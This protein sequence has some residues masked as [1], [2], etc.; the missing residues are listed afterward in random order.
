MTATET[1]A[2]W[3]TAGL[4]LAILLVGAVLGTILAA[5]VLAIAGAV[6]RIP[7]VLP[8][9][10]RFLTADVDAPLMWVLL[11]SSWMLGIVVT[12][13]IATRA[14]KSRAAGPRS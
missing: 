13:A 9:L 8:L 14:L 7:G 11:V 12:Y 4:Y 5:L 2:H 1:L 3:R 10:D 6:I